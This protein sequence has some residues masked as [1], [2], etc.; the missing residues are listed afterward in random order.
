MQASSGHK[1]ETK[2]KGHKCHVAQFL[3]SV[4]A[5]AII[6]FLL[7]MSSISLGYTRDYESLAL[8]WRPEKQLVEA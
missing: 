1:R 7:S 5:L 4:T 6:F 8:S 2:K 3:N